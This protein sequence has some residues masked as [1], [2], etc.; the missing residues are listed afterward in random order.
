MKTYWKPILFAAVLAAA[1]FVIFSNGPLNPNKVSQQMQESIT[2]SPK[3]LAKYAIPAIRTTTFTPSAIS[4][5]PS[6]SN[7]HQFFFSD[8]FAPSK[9]ISG[10][11][12][13]PSQPGTYPIILLLR[14]WADEEVY[15]P[16]YGTKNA[17]AY[18]ARNGF[19]AIAPDFLGYGDSD[20][21]SDDFA[22]ARFQTY[23]AAITLFKSLENFNPA[24]TDQHLSYTLDTTHTGIWGHSNGG[25]VAL[26]ILA[27]L[28]EPIP[29]TMWAPVTIPFPTNIL[30]YSKDQDDGGALIRALVKAFQ[31]NYDAS[32]FTPNTFLEDIT[33]P[34]ILHQGTADEAV[35]K[36][37]NDDFVAIMKKLN[38]DITYYEYSGTDHNLRPAWGTV[39]ARDV[40]FFKAQFDED[41][42]DTYSLQD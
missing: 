20:P 41:Q 22:E 27:S 24:L 29:T 23:T 7:I 10:T 13:L 31:Q 9:R 32:Q 17:A 1:A 37:W 42:V 25:Q 36:K 14:G 3:P 11:I 35:P 19:I 12:T 28:K 34:I 33:A 6:T 16:G 21:Y 5:D 4:I 2:P 26:Y 40:A 30:H 39:I 8:S 18:F 38:K 15:Y